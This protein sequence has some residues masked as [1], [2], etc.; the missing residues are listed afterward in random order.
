MASSAFEQLDERTH[1][2]ITLALAKCSQWGCKST[3][4]SIALDIL[5]TRARRRARDANRS[6]PK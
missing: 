3:P 5:S 2:N 4:E 1:E 6:E